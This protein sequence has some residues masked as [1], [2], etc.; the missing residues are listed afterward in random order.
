MKI[1]KGLLITL[2]AL[3]VIWIILAL[4]SPKGYNVSRE[5]TTEASLEKVWNQI[6]TFEKWQ[7]WS[8]W[9]INDSNLKS[10]YE[11]TSGS[12]GSMT[13][14]VGDP[15]S[16]TGNMTIT[17]VIPNSKLGYDLQFEEFPVSKGFIEITEE[18]G[19]STISWNNK[20]DLPF[21][22]RPVTFFGM[23]DNM[24]GP[25]FEVGLLILKELAESSP[26]PLKKEI[27][28]SQVEMPEVN[29][30]GIRHKTTMAK[31]MTKE[32]F[33]TNYQT[34]FAAIGEVNIQV[35]GNSSCIYY[36]WNELDSTTEVFPCVSVSS[37]LEI[38]P[39]GLQL[40][41]VPAS[42]A[43][44]STYYGS[45]EES[46][47]THLKIDDYCKEYNLKTGLVIE[48]YVNAATATSEDEL[49]TNIYY[50]IIE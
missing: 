17:E 9:K 39:V 41:L 34:I 28:V 6:S 13:S 30:L 36:S 40:V 2:L 35:T 48:E 46:M 18:N 44:K 26:E 7:N 49:I 29:C 31:V 12:V 24:M 20:G 8:P 16:G 1:I 21:F 43:V 19:I 37:S 33:E 5:I 25:N 45:A 22:M 47:A 50:Q 10:K 23:F 15:Q 14:W 38:A 11:G 3:L 4:F 32:F 42:R 27:E